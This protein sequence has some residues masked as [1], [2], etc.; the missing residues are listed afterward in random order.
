MTNNYV[1]VTKA[2]IQSDQM[3][4][5]DKLVIQSEQNDNLTRNY[6]VTDELRVTNSSYRVNNSYIV[7]TK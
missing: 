5:F 4:R 7:D 1:F 6:R 3:F 2:R